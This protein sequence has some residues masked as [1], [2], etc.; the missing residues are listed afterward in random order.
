MS[1]PR[2]CLTICRPEEIN[3]SQMAGFNRVVLSP[4]PG[5]PEETE[6]LLPLIRLL[7]P[8]TPILGVCLG[9]Q[10]LALAFGGR[11][12]NLKKVYHGLASKVIILE[13]DYLFEGLPPEILAGRYHSWLVDSDNFPQELMVTAVDDTGQI[14][15]LAHREYNVRGVQ[16]HP[17]SILTPMG[18]R[19]LRNFLVGPAKRE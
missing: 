1:A 16:F 18:P 11:L 6:N 5:L 2:D 17:E 9:H 4:G 7:A 19:L 14:M 10:A 12:L 15:G 8:N 13:P 3:L